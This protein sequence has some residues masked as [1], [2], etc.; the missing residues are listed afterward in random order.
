MGTEGNAQTTQPEWHDQLPSDLKGHKDLLQP[1]IG[2]LAKGYLER[3][4]K[5][6]D[7]EGKLQRAIFTVPTADTPEADRVAFRKAFGI[8][9]KP[10]AYPLEKP[11][12][13]VGF[14]YSEETESGFRKLCHELSVPSDTAKRL[15]GFANELRAKEYEDFQKKS[16]EQRTA[17]VAALRTAWKDQAEAN[18]AKL[19]ALA[20]KYGKDKAEKLAKAMLS[21]EGMFGDDPDAIELLLAIANDVLPE[22]MQPGKPRQASE[23]GGLRNPEIAARFPPKG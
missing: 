22:S 4:V 20:T 6:Q 15:Y 1:K 7:L 16:K 13:P 5:L 2:E 10:E 19:T 14:T 18:A 11:K 23:G 9:D 8:P 21:E 12:L 17:R 3:G